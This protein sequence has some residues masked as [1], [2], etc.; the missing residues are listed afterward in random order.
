M[1]SAPQSSSLTP[2]G[3]GAAT[4]SFQF[5]SGET[6]QV[7]LGSASNTLP[8]I[9][10]AINSANIGLQA[11]VVSS[12]AGYQLSLTGQ[13][14]AANAFTIGVSGNAGVDSLL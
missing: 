10:S 4:L 13:S 14:G 12:S 7:A 1:S 5:A 9:A 11:Q 8:G 3:N 6:R 2:I